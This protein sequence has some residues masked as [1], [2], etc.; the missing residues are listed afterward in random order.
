MPVE[1]SWLADDHLLAKSSHDPSLWSLEENFPL[2]IPFLL[3]LPV[4]LDQGPTL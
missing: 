4:I 1:F 3:R 2:T